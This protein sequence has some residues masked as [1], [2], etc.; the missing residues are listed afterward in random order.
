MAV[1]GFSEDGE[2]KVV[3][4]CG[5]TLAGLLQPSPSASRMTNGRKSL[6]VFTHT[7]PY[8]LMSG[9]R[10]RYCHL[11]R[12]L[13]DRFDL[14]L[15][16]LAD[17]SAEQVHAE[18]LRGWCRE[19]RVVP[20]QKSKPSFAK[21]VKN[22]LSPHPAD[23]NHEDPRVAHAF[24]EILATRPVDGVLIWTT[25]LASYISLIP[26]RIKRALDLDD[27]QFVRMRRAVSELPWG[28][29]KLGYLLEPAKVKRFERRMLRS[30]NLAF[31]CSDTDKRRVIELGT[32]VPVEIIPNGVDPERFTAGKYPEWP[33]PSLVYTG[34]LGSQGGQGVL[35]FMREVYPLIRKRIPQVKLHLVGGYVIPEV[36][37][38]V[39]RDSSVSLAEMVEDIRPYM[40]GGWV[41]IV[42]LWVGSGTRIKIL[43]ACAMEKPVVSTPVGAEGLELTTGDHLFVEEEPRGFAAR[44]VE[45]LREPALRRAV[46]LKAREAVC[47]RYTWS[48]IGSLAAEILDGLL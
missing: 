32:G 29:K 44:C 39:A 15:L 18:H 36:R 2:V 13:A 34:G 28:K 17:S 31:T 38:A 9:G 12:H 43:E 24:S 40:A 30:V 27:L 48:T 5:P 14:Y 6:L 21:K 16:S 22:L 7:V 1:A 25:F 46:G 23:L 10:I 8:P 4:R 3:G 26:P 37:Q 47:A 20:F 35:R 41:L 19:V 45:L 33:E 42:P 11:L